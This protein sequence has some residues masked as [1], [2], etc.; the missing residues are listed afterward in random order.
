MT[1]FAPVL[2]WIL[3]IRACS[4]FALAED[5]SDPPKVE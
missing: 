4:P 5:K 2:A 3:V 1:R